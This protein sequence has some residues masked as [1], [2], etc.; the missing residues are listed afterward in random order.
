LENDEL[1]NAQLLSL[2]LLFETVNARLG[3]KSSMSLR[4][5]RINSMPS[6]PMSPMMSMAGSGSAPGVKS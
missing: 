5:V 2:E 4:A 3:P 1:R 6:K